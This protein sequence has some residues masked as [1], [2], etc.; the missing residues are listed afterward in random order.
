MSNV[1]I[2]QSSK[3]CSHHECD[4]FDELKYIGRG[5]RGW[6]LGRVP[7]PWDGDAPLKIHY[8]SVQAPAHHLA[9]FPGRNP[10]S[11]PVNTHFISI[12]KKHALLCRTTLAFMLM[13]RYVEQHA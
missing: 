4:I 13:P 11:A 2:M 3:T 7:T 10:V 8:Y 6:A 9:P 12:P 1:T 5:F